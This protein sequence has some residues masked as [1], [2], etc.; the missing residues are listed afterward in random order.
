MRLVDWTSGEE[1][2]RY[3]PAMSGAHTALFM[4]RIAR[5]SPQA[6]WKMSTIGDV[7]HTARDWG[8]LVPEVAEQGLQPRLQ[9][10]CNRLATRLPPACNAAQPS[11]L[12]GPSPS[13]TDSPERSRHLPHCSCRRHLPHC[14]CRRLMPHC[15]CRRLMAY[16]S[17]RRLMPTAHADSSSSSPLL[18]LTRARVCGFWVC[19]QIK[20]YSTD[21]V[22]G[23]Q[24]DAS[25]RVALLRKGGVIRLADYAPQGVPPMLVLGLAWDVTKGVNIDLDASVIAFSMPHSH[26]APAA[27]LFLTQCTSYLCSVG[28]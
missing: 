13:P 15:S 6:A 26:S 27:T 12:T 19:V 10:A 18:L 20:A 25:E 4:C 2:C 28:Y 1:M 23:L 7:D 11:N 5:A 16:C 21:I 17:C 24:V 3:Y 22:K 14:S 9:P 8:T